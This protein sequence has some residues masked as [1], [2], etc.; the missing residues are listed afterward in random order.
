MTEYLLYRAWN[1]IANGQE[2]LTEPDGEWVEAAK[3]WRMS[4]MPILT[5]RDE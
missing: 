5:T 3:A 4:F 1:I 2:W